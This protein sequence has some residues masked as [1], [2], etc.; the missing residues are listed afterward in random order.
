MATR[1]SHS[2]IIKKY[3]DCIEE[4]V[5]NAAITPGHLVEVISGGKIRVH[6]TASGNVF[7]MFALEDELQGKGIDE[8]FS[9]LDPVQVWIPTRGD[10]V[11]ALLKDGE[12]I[13]E[14]DFLEAYS[15][16]TLRK[17][18]T[19]HWLSTNVGTVYPLV[20]VGVATEAVDLS[21]SDGTHPASGRRIKVRIV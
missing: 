3:S 5:A 13:V 4:F 15:D 2:V 19:E 10:I 20:I 9:A 6:A 11:N 14:G 18:V 8:A 1:V 16:G 12:T 21:G 17:Y 7:P